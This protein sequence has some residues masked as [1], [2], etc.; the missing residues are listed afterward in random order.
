MKKSEAMSTTPITETSSGRKVLA[1]YEF[2]RMCR[3]FVQENKMK[4][5]IPVMLALAASTE[6]EGGVSMSVLSRKLGLSEDAVRQGCLRTLIKSSYLLCFKSDKTNSATKPWLIQIPAYVHTVD[7]DSSDGRKMLAILNDLTQ[8]IERTQGRIQT[9][10]LAALIMLGLRVRQIRS[11]RDMNSYI[12]DLAKSA[13]TCQRILER[14]AV[15]GLLV[16][17]KPTSNNKSPT[18]ITLVA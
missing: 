8:A 3:I 18:F 10:A 7:Q 15:L 5:F 12:G 14:L 17:T 11:I 9:S 1:P 4:T 6:A 2:E 13:F 16:L